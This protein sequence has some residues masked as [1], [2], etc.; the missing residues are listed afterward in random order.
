MAVTPMVPAIAIANT[1]FFMSDSR[2][3]W[4]YNR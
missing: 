3:C 4:N 2:F 1:A